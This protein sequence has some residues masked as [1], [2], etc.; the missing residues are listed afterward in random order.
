MANT[1]LWGVLVEGPTIQTLGTEHLMNRWADQLQSF[2]GSRPL[3]VQRDSPGDDWRLTAHNRPGADK[4]KRVE[5]LLD[6]LNDARRQHAALEH[7][8]RTTRVPHP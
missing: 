1:N 7:T 4:R 8:D 5:R 2:W 6:R 3:T